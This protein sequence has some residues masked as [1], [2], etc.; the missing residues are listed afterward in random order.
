MVTIATW[1]G[2]IDLK[3]QQLV[4][5]VHKMTPKGKMDIHMK[6]ALVQKGNHELYMWDTPR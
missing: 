2:I 4:I 1:K 3:N 6:H 5:M